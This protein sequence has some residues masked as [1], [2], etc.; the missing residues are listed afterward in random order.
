MDVTTWMAAVSC[1]IVMLAWFVLPG[2]ATKG[3]EAVSATELT[4]SA[5]KEPAT[6]AA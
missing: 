2:S 6:S 5:Q 1:G 3:S 4:G